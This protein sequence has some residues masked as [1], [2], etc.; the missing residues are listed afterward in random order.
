MIKVEPMEAHIHHKDIDVTMEAGG[1]PAIPQ[2]S[3]GS[4][5][6]TTITRYKFVQ[7]QVDLISQH[8]SYTN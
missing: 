7:C 8:Y 4:H 6:S 5:P 1:G 2:S 3:G